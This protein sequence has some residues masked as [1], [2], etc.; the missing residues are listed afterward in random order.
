[1]PPDLEP[2]SAQ[3]PAYLRG[4]HDLDAN[5]ADQYQQEDIKNNSIYALAR[6]ILNETLEECLNTNNP[7]VSPVAASSQVQPL[8]HHLL[9]SRAATT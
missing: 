9:R 2:F 6:Q 7:V 5:W 8:E 3:I 1:M 4:L